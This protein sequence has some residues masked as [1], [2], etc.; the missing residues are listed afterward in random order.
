MLLS[1]CRSARFNRTKLSL[2]H[3]HTNHT[4]DTIMHSVKLPEFR[5]SVENIIS[6]CYINKHPTIS[7]WYGEWIFNVDG[8]LFIYLLTP[9]CVCVFF[10]TRVNSWG[11]RLSITIS[12]FN[13]AHKWRAHSQVMYTD[14]P[15][16]P[17]FIIIICDIQPH[18]EH[19]HWSRIT[20]RRCSHTKYHYPYNGWVW[21]HKSQ[22]GMNCAICSP[23]VKQQ[24]HYY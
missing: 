10:F 19:T 24:L 8:C 20:Y 11:A 14:K 1:N 16:S 23:T 4:P 17:L 22:V 21:G 3:T 13:C 2:A 12:Q 5:V 7:V 15:H 18:V 9:V 6:R